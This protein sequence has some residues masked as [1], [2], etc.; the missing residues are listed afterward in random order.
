MEWH[1]IQRNSWLS[2]CGRGWVMHFDDL[3][4]PP[5]FAMW[6]R[7]EPGKGA[8][9]PLM[10]GNRTAYRRSLEAAKLAVERAFHE[11]KEAA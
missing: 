5:Y 10:T 11:M 3:G 8:W 2:T 6:R 1:S 4:K 7:R 9:M